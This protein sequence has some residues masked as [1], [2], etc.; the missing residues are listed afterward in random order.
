MWSTFRFMSS[1]A[2]D[3]CDPCRPKSDPKPKGNYD[4]RMFTPEVVKKHKGIWPVIAIFGMTMVALPTFIS[5]WLPRKNDLNVTG[6][7]RDR[8]PEEFYDVMHP[9]NQKFVTFNKSYEP[10]PELNAALAYRKDYWKMRRKEEKQ[11]AREK[12]SKSTFDNNEKTI[13][14]SQQFYK[15]SD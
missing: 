13:D 11:N 14:I 10:M 4:L 3:P 5:I 8:A 9:K 7:D 12:I 1:D 15:I 6:R 2:F